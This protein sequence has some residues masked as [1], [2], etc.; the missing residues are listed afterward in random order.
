[1]NANAYTTGTLDRSGGS[2]VAS[3]R[4]RDI[5]SSGYAALF[6]VTSGNPGTPAALGEA[7]A[8][9]L[10]SV[11]RAGEQARECNDQRQ[12]SQFNKALDAARKALTIEPNLAA[13]HICMATVYEAQRMPLDSQLV[14][15]Q[16]AARAA[17]PTARPWATV[18]RWSQQ[19]ADTYK[20]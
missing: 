18:A 7:I 1:M 12:K 19:R 20:G 9:R 17:S 16:R 6:S 15:Y 5:G 11:V 13:A 3:I 2:L 10:N 4:V 14:A 8:Q